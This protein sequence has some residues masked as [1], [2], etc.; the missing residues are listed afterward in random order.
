MDMTDDGWP[1]KEIE[2]RLSNKRVEARGDP[3]RAT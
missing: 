3:R 1:W 2:K